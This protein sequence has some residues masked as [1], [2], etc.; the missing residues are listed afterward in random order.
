MIAHQIGAKSTRDAFFLSNF[1]V[2][3]LPTMLIVSSLI[4]IGVV[5]VASRAMVRHGPARLVPGAFAV[6]AALL[7]AEWALSFES[8]RVAAIAVY[9][10]VAT[11]GTL[12]ISG[13]WSMVN[14]RFD[15]RT[16]K[17][18]IGR[19]AGGGALGGVVGGVVAERVGTGLSVTTMLPVLAILHL[20]CALAVRGLRPVGVAV[21]G[22]AAR[23]PRPGA[24][25]PEAAAESASLHAGFR[26]LGTAPYLRS[27]AVL[28][29]LGAV[30][31]ALLDY[32]FK[33][34]ATQS[35]TRGADLIRF[36]AI[37]YT[38]IGLLTFLVQTSLSRLSLE[39]LGLSRTVAVLPAAVGAGGLGALLVP[40]LASAGLARGAEAVLR[41]SLFRSA[42]EVLYTPIPRHQKR[43][44]KTLVDVGFDRLGDAIGGSLIKL[45]LMLGPVLAGRS[46]L[47]LA[48]VISAAG[49]VVAIRLQEGY[50]RVLKKSLLS[51]AVELDVSDVED[52]TTRTT[53]METVR[54]DVGTFAADSP[55]L[56]RDADPPHGEL[57]E[58]AARLAALGSGDP[59]RVRSA[60]A[61]PAG[62]D[63]KL[64]AY[65][66]PLLAWDEVAPQAVQ[67]LRGLA[68][69]TAG[70]LV[71]ALL[72]SQQPFAVRRRLPSVLS[73]AATQRAVDGLMGGLEDRRFEVRYQCAAGLAR[74]RQ[75]VPNVRIEPDQ[76]F[77]A[78]LQEVAV[79]QRVWEGQRLL[80][81]AAEEGSPF[82]DEYL[83][84]RSNRSLE[85]VFTLLSLALPGEPLKVAFRG[86]H[87]D[88]E[89]LRGTALEY[90]ETVLP[91]PIRERL[92]PFLEDRR[93]KEPEG[94]LRED[95]LADLMRS[96]ES[97]QI[98]LEELRRRYG[99]ASPL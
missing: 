9:L 35:F 18:R 39:R 46:L 52:R 82:V 5:L 99:D 60:L 59:E 73:A 83:R 74:L 42:Y 96:S 40:G 7:L 48:I 98:N 45:V 25:A 85:H 29:L 91:A 80:D 76:V 34:R 88:D 36:F 58:I 21:P 6:S 95:V 26:I 16:A 53:V 89:A 43:A 22:R 38:A 15:P 24:T 87:T 50:V 17:R 97:I 92:W 33:S 55:R 66:I 64:V 44:T 61:A 11:F 65:V 27:L 23:D 51:R 47:G 8:R 4:S 84:G 2:T 1:D 63:P 12:L 86:M 67:A 81:L 20:L 32:V 19:I 72:D 30:S 10:H 49:F 77:G 56:A 79:G 37:F 94:R 54:L 28:V 14:E 93:R 75:K 68:A 71:D 90:L 70:Q 78:V 3:F 41:S 31:T 69:R 62:L 13:F 57:A